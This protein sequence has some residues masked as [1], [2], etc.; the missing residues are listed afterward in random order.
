MIVQPYRHTREVPAYIGRFLIFGLLAGAFG[1]ADPPC[2]T[3][4]PCA[5]AL[6]SG[7]FAERPDGV[8]ELDALPDAGSV[9]QVGLVH[10]SVLLQ[11]CEHPLAQTFV[12]VSVA[13][14]TNAAHS[15]VPIAA[16]HV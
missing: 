9:Q 6:L 5:A 7:I 16:A 3:A 2:L 4:V 14:C 13:V 8:V 15:V 12:V 11:A 10:F 1:S